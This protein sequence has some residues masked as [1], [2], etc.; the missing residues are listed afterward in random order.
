MAFRVGDILH[1]TG[2]PIYPAKGKFCVLIQIAP[3]RFFLINTEN[4]KEYDCIPL[5]KKGRNFPKHDSFIGCKN[6]F[7]AE[8][9]QVD[10][11]VGKINNEELSALATKVRDSKFIA[12]IQK[13]PILKAIEMEFKNRKKEAP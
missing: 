4:R 3:N 11:K 10:S 1:V 2:L 6:I 12:K 13:D 8:D 7:H 9:S 5:S